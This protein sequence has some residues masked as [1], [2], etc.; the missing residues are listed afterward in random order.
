MAGRAGIWPEVIR[1]L[2][3]PQSQKIIHVPT[4]GLADHSL[5]D[6]LTRLGCIVLCVAKFEQVTNYLLTE[7]MILRTVPE[8][9]SGRC[10]HA[11]A[12]ATPG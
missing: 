5:R 6:I 2:I 1:I 7:K 9:I 8:L 3:S 11:G 12:S 10:T 4:E